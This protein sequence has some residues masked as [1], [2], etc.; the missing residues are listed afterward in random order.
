MAVV[1]AL[2]M[3]VGAFAADGAVALAQDAPGEYRLPSTN[4][5]RQDPDSSFGSGLSRIGI[6]LIN[7]AAGIVGTLVLAYA[8]FQIILDVWRAIKGGQE[9]R[10]LGPRL[11]LVGVGAMIVLMSVTGSW[12]P[13]IKS[14]YEGIIGGVIGAFGGGS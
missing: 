8:F 3:L 7:W 9:L 2:V 12:Y 11:V 4:Y 6:R 14:L 1:L 5:F 10:A 13:I